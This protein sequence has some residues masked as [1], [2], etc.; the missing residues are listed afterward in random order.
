[1]RDFLEVG[2]LTSVGVLL[3]SISSVT[4]LDLSTQE[5]TI[6]VK[7]CDEIESNCNGSSMESD[8]MHK[9]SYNSGTYQVR[10]TIIGKVLIAC[11]TERWTQFEVDELDGFTDDSSVFYS[12]HIYKDSSYCVEVD[13]TKLVIWLCLKPEVP[14]VAQTSK[15]IPI[16]LPRTEWL[17]GFRRGNPDISLRKPKATSAAGA[18]AFNRSQVVLS[19]TLI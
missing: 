9:F 12:N 10:L 4:G 7:C 14:V 15:V 11:P 17:A 19:S 1:M 5:N 13:R 2:L 18:Q 6:A 8:Y 16:Y 3:I